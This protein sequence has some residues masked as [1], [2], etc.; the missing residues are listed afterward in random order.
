MK[1]DKSLFLL[2][3]SLLFPSLALAASVSGTVIYE[4]EVPKLREIKMDADPICLTK[5]DGAVNPKTI[6]LG[7]NKEMEFVFLHIVEGLP[8]K[9]YP[10]PSEP[11]ILDQK[12][13]MYDPPVVGVM[14][15]QPVKILNPDGTLHNV[16]ALCKI[17]PEFNLAMP[18]FRKE[19]TKIFEKEEFMFPMKCDVH[20]WMSTY[21]SVLKHPYF[22]TTNKEG[23]YTIDNLPPGDYVVEAWQQRLDPQ[24][25]SFTVAE[26]ETKEI[27]FTF[28]RPDK[29]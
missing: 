21:V 25:V 16:H 13:C 2:F 7:P 3:F 22:T 28:S 10:T 20:P 14:V 29:K 15:G 9:N 5:H 4:G 8:N 18:K 23:K 11:V 19:V 6:N 1:Y 24:R 17:N 26:G 27:N 12:G